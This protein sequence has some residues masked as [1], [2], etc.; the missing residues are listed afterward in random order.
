IA[1]EPA[2]ADSWNSRCWARGLVG[3]LDAA[4]ADCDEALR[5]LVR[6]N[7]SSEPDS[8]LR[9]ATYDSRGLVNLKLN[10]LTEAMT[11]YEA[12]LRLDQKHVGALYGRGLVKHKMGDL[13]GATADTVAARAL[14]PDI[15]EEFKRY[16][17]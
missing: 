14:K 12:A 10:R 13:V 5:L 4:L 3:Q 2:R 11:D 1:L 6:R 8:A 17:V 7:A 16:G 9:S 15:E